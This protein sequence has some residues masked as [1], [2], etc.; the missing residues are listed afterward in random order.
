MLKF[1]ISL[2]DFLKWFGGQ[3]G[4]EIIWKQLIRQIYA[5]IWSLYSFTYFNLKTE[6]DSDFFWADKNIKVE[7]LQSKALI[8]L[9]L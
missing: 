1:W 4:S 3:L 7:I 6:R 2:P 5:S 8:D 9:R